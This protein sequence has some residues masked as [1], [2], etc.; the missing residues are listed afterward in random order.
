LNAG[1][2]ETALNHLQRALDQDPDNDHA[3]YILAVALSSRE[4]PDRALHHL[5]RAI[6][7]NPD[8]RSLARQ[9]PDLESVRDLDEFRSVLDVPSA[10]AKSRPRGRR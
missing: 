3:H 9:D 1:D 6:S 4:Q 7:L 8:N 10:F 2:A 5:R